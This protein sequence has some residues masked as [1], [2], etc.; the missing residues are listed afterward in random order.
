M[1]LLLRWY[2]MRGAASRGKSPCCVISFWH[3]FGRIA[4]EPNQ[5][6]ASSLSGTLREEI[7]RGF[8]HSD[9][10]RRCD[11]NPLVQSNSVLLRQA[12]GSFLN[13]ER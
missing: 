10:F 9:F 12:L 1:D 11:S 5:S 8:H 3:D 13:R 7:R 6:V 4:Q 2:E